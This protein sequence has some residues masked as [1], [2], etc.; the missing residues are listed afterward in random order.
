MNET[1]KNTETR[2]GKVLSAKRL[3]VPITAA[4]LLMQVLILFNTVHIRNLNAYIAD[5]TQR[6]FAITAATNGLSR[7]TDEMTGAATRYVGGDTE[8]L[9]DYLSAFGEME[10]NYSALRELIALPPTDAA[11][12][13]PQAQATEDDPVRIL[14]QARAAVAG[15]YE[16]ERTAMTMAAQAKIKST[17]AQFAQVA[18][19]KGITGT[20]LA[21]MLL[22]EEG[23]DDVAVERVS[24]SLTDHYDPKNMVLRLS[25]STAN[26]TSVA[27]LGVAAHEC[28]H[29]LQHRDAYGPLMLRT[30]AVPVV[31]ISSNVAW[32]LFVLGLIMSWRPLLT[33]G[34]VMFS[35]AVLFALITLPVEFNASSRALAALSAHGYLDEQELSGARKVLNAAAL[36]YVASAAMAVMQLLR[37][38]LIA[39]RR[40]R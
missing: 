23:V 21:R 1:H 18:S 31:N 27:A 16:T 17:Y 13:H 3:I 8:A 14:E 5:A 6:N 10:G 11:T 35:L 38:L 4:I 29:V 7:A 12:I 34:I 40:R 32:P 20:Q 9:S 30:A 33:A 24:G 22:H 19:R 28:G 37:L 36:T 39:N 26:S 25:D 2:R 15:R